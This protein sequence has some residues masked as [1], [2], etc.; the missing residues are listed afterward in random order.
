VL[1]ARIRA[2]R[3]VLHSPFARFDDGP[4]SAFAPVSGR[5]RPTTRASGPRSAERCSRLVKR[6]AW[7]QVLAFVSSYGYAFLFGVSLAE[8]VFLLGFIM[9]GD[10]AV[11]LGG[12]LASRGYL[13]LVKVVVAVIVGLLFGSSFSF[14]LGRRGGPSL[15]ARWEARLAG[16]RPHLRT[17]EDYFSEH[18]AKTV[19]LASFITGIKN[20]VPV[21]AG[22]SRMSFPR[23]IFYSAA[24]STVRTLA[25]VAIG[26][27]FG[28]NLERAARMMGSVNGFA[29]AVVGGCALLFVGMRWA[30]TRRLARRAGAGAEDGVDRLPKG[31]DLGD[32]SK[33]RGPEAAPPGAKGASLTSRPSKES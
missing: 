18:G 7:Q 26:Y 1:V 2:A 30:K 10:L 16:G 4:T 25:L 27:A 15:A 23:F 19:F 21:A 22:A 3:A 11:V 28:A 13:D 14:W 32:T 31:H 17:V 29:M 9:P 8:N 20:V 24:G 12:A 6:M 33:A 5:A